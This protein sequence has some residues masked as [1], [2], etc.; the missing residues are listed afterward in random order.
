MPTLPSD[1]AAVHEA[2]RGRGSL[3]QLAEG[4]RLFV[5]QEG[6]GPDLILVHGFPSSSHD[7]AAALPLLTGHFRV[8]LFDQLGFGFSDKPPEASYSLLEQG[9]RAGELVRGLGVSQAT[10]I[11]H[12]MGLTVAVE[13]LCRHE[14]G[15]LGFRMDGLVLCN[16]SHLVEL[17][18]I[19]QLQKDLMTDQGAAAF[20]AAYDPERFAQAFRFVWGDPSRTPEV[21]IRAIA[22]WLSESLPVLAKIARYNLERERYAE[23]WRSILT[24]AP[25]PIDIVWGDRDPIAVIEIGRRLAEMT[26]GRLAIIEGVGHYP[27]MEDPARWVAALRI[28]EW[29]SRTT[30]T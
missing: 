8:T 1:V 14:V 5:V 15:E 13:M 18:N 29:V 16:G 22:Y 23:R 30:P 11:G 12:D 24:R 25:L 27:Q 21:D 7:F 2:W 19:T 6:S 26:Q 9:R 17:A 20:A 4:H 28:D 3:H 10:V